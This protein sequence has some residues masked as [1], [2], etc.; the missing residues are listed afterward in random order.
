[1]GAWEDLVLSKTVI[2]GEGE[3]TVYRAGSLIAYRVS[4]GNRASTKFSQA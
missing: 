3:V 2:I 1:M 4:G